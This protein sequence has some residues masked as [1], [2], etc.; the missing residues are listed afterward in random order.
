MGEGAKISKEQIS[1]DFQYVRNLIEATL[2]PLVVVSH[3]GRITDMNEALTQSTGIS[4]KELKG[5]DFLNY[6]TEPVKAQNL[7]QE[8]FQNGA[9]IGFPLKLR[10]S[11]G[12]L[13][14]LLFNGSVFKNSAGQVL[15]AV[16][17]ARDV[18]DQ[19][20]IKSEMHY[21]KLYAELG[22]KNAEKAQK[23]AERIMQI[24]EAAMKAKQ[25]F[26][27]NMSHEIR[28]PMNAIIGFTKVVLKTQLTPKQK[29]Y[30]TA[31]KVSGDALIVLINDILDLAKV[32]SGKMTFE[33][34]PF[35]IAGS[36]SSM[37]QLF[38][39]KIQEKNLQLVQ[40]YDKKIPEVLI[41]DPVRF[42]QIILNL[43]SNAVK[44]TKKGKITVS[45]YL[46]SE[47]N[48]KVTIE[49]TVTDTG[50]G[51]EEDKTEKIF[52][53]FEQ[54]TS[55]TSRL[56][57]GTGLG[58][59][60]SKKLVEAQDGTIS[61][62]SRINEGSSFRFTLTFQ[63]SNGN[64]DLEADSLD[65][66]F[67]GMNNKIL[68]VE[69][70]LLNQLLMKTLLEDLNFECD[71]ASNGKIAIEKLQLNSYDLI[72]MDLQM[73]VMNGFE[74]T[75]F[76]R[77]TMRSDI[78]IIALTA[79]VTT[80]DLKKCK[81]VGMNDYVAK[82]VD[83]RLLYNKMIPLLSKA[84]STENDEE[85]KNEVVKNDER[86]INLEYLKRRTKSDPALMK[87][88]ISLYLDQTSGL[89]IEMR[90]ASEEMDWERLQAIA[91][92]LIPSFSIVGIKNNFKD[93]AV[94]IQ[95]H[96]SMQEEIDKI[97]ALVSNLENILLQACEELKEEY[98]K[99]DK[100]VIN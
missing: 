22:T 73:P 12:S 37:I 46:L 31:I 100:N 84:L 16:M 41:G 93:M 29:E 82:P 77:N 94:K 62:N 51:I 14:E 65:L 55:E 88:M 3:E 40:V 54:S 43:M 10:H 47:D 69:D 78:P 95:E 97:P 2:D 59:A 91:H 58:L 8:V 6:F 68:V 18:T 96:A 80:M 13:T 60:I 44:F 20:R 5:S 79:D 38:E 4:R 1:E 21:E 34:I 49:T 66:D 71:I 50:I 63:K 89:I 28:T 92:K 9:V 25:Q 27:S 67:D 87:E 85:I 70:M 11:D 72:L 32:D 15:G 56:Y 61:V 64:I 7:Y 75:E 74:T 99:I 83:D 39:P 23:E 90:K 86:Y 53:N 35:K 33:K 81:A 30:L 36:L 42:N 17:V 98:A 24:S 76:I 48:E 52:E 26:L 57:G 45:T 19:N